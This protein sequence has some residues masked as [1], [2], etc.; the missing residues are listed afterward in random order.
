MY[1]FER[2]MHDLKK[3]LLNKNHVEASIC[4]SNILSETTFF[5]SHY[6]GFDI[7]TRLSHQLRNIVGGNDDMDN[8]LCIFKHRG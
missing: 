1:P 7:E 2:K 3:K 8:C 6:F 4:E 5:C